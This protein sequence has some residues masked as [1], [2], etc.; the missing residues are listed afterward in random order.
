MLAASF[1][2][3]T[4]ALCLKIRARLA[5]CFRDIT[6][7]ANLGSEMMHEFLLMAD[8]YLNLIP[9][10]NCGQAQPLAIFYVFPLQ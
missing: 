9:S 2:G 6:M 8:G 1:A 4:L 5:M 10:G 3:Y 7:P